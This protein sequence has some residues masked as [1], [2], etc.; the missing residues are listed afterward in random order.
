MVYSISIMERFQEVP[1]V[2]TTECLIFSRVECNSNICT[3]LVKKANLIGFH[4]VELN[5]KEA[6]IKF[7]F[8]LKVH[9]GCVGFQVLSRCGKHDEW[10]FLMNGIAR[11]VFELIELMHIPRK[12]QGT[13]LIMFITLPE[14]LSFNLLYTMVFIPPLERV[15]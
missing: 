14:S 7:Y 6:K 15:I 2:P 12:L 1:L 8:L 13:S 10:Q 9:L 3:I 4:Q 5:F 11:F